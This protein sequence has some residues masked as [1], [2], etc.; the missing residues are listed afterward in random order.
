MVVVCWSL[1]GGMGT[2]VVAAGLALAA[3]RRGDQPWL[4][5]LEGDLPAALGVDGGGPGLA[6]WCS[7]VDGPGP[8][9][10]DRLAAEAGGVRVV[11]RGAAVWSDA[12]PARV[13]ALVAYLADMDRPVVV[14]AGN[15]QGPPGV[16]PAPADAL[17][18]V[19]DRSIL[20]TR[21]CYLALRRVPVQTR[22]PTEVALM[23]E[24]GRAL[25]RTDIEQVV[26]APVTIRVPVDPAVAWAVDSGLLGRRPPRVL[27]R[28]VGEAT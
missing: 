9:A 18:D 4:L 23:A 2:T 21:A 26:G 8:E 1:K 14:D 10:V 19:A 15:L 13:A 16:G 22:R 27:L 7:A 12:V 17:L 3:A 5:D 24:P 20:V 25:G 11:A 28:S 6:D